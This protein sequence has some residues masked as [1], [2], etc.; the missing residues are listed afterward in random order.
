MSVPGH[1]AAEIRATI[2]AALEN[3]TLA[4][5]TYN[6]TLKLTQSCDPLSLTSPSAAIE[7]VDGGFVVV[8][9][10]GRT[11][12]GMT[13]MISGGTVQRMWEVPFSI[14]FSIDTS[15][16]DGEKLSV[17]LLKFP[18]AV[19]RLVDAALEPQTGANLNVTTIS[20]APPVRQA[21]G[22]ILIYEVTY[23]IKF[24]FA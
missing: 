5:M 18:A 21:G 24:A 1:T 3:Q 7:C 2:I 10:T 16:Y 4:G 17:D 15:A 14:K 9:G 12:A 8:P 22:S 6:T 20:E 19:R 11:I 13:P 23:A